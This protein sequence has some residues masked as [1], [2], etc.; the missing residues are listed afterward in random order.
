[1]ARKRNKWGVV[2]SFETARFTIELEMEREHGYRYDGDD[3]DGSAQ[4]ALNSGELVAFGSIV[5]V[6]LDGEEIASDSLWGSV[7]ESGNTAEFFTAH[8]DS[9][10]MN[11]NCSIMRANHPAGPR[12]SI[13]H[14][15]PDMVRIAVKAAREHVAAMPDKPK[16]RGAK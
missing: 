2:W 8:R 15:F 7:Y 11:R 16:L 13:C 3:E 10:P 6:L 1:M 4:R 9:D 12:I 5:R 14:Y